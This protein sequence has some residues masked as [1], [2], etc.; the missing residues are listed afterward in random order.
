MLHIYTYVMT[1]KFELC[2]EIL[3]ISRPKIE[4]LDK[5]SNWI[6]PSYHTS[7]CDKENIQSQLRRL[8]FV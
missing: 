5:N 8:H 3:I 7:Y 1:I 4:H 6:I 2:F